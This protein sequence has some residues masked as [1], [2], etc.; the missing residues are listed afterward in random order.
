MIYG[1]ARVSTKGQAREQPGGAGRRAAGGRG[2]TNLF[3]R[4]Y[5]HESPPPRP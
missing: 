4:L 3:G 2:G 1:Y 5:R